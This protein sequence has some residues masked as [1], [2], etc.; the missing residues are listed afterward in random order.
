METTT[1][2]PQA[3]YR[4]TTEQR[5]NVREAYIQG[6]GSLRV[7]AERF[8]ISFSTV[9]DWHFEEGWT[10]LRNKYDANSLAKLAKSIEP[11]ATVV[12]AETPPVTTQA[13]KLAVVEKQLENVDK[14]LTECED[15]KELNS[16]TQ[17]KERLLNAWALLTGFERPGVRK[18]KRTRQTIADIQPIPAEPQPVYPT[19]SVQPAKPLGW[20]YD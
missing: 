8:G 20:E 18:A 10:E 15:A 3:R 13:G 19:A 1:E 6:K 14:L 7:L 4:P 2:P 17:A 5:R 9:K 11:A 12:I 16:L